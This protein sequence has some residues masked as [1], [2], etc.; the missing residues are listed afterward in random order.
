[1][2]MP[3][4]TTITII[5]RRGA[6]TIILWVASITG[7][8]TT[9]TRGIRANAYRRNI[10]SNRRAANRFG[11]IRASPGLN[12]RLKRSILRQPCSIRIWRHRPPSL[13]R[14]RTAECCV[15]KES[16]RLA[17]HYVECPVKQTAHGQILVPLFFC[18]G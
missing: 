1:M 6:S 11:C 15:M 12:I 9:I 4:P 8:T 10:I 14:G 18:A 3:T 7:T 2:S 17:R 16:G 5:I 13:H